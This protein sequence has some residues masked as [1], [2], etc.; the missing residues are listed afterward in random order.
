[1]W[2]MEYKLHTT[3]FSLLCSCVLDVRSKIFDTVFVFI[4][5]VVL[6]FHCGI[7][8]KSMFL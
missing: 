6:N 2:Y 7:N 4:I 5:T 3:P 1:M 8:C